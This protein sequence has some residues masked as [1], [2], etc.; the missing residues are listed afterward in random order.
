MSF[1]MTASS[2]M[3]PFSVVAALDI[4]IVGKISFKKRLYSLIGAACDTAVQLDSCIRKGI[5][6]PHT[7]SSAD[8]GIHSQFRQ[9]TCQRPV[10]ASVGIRD[11][12]FC[13]L[14]V[15]CIIDLKLLR[16][17]K[18]LINISVFKSYCYSHCIFSFL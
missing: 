16:V 8:Q 5:L 4:R 12:L 13:D 18:M 9:E 10:S 2:V 17:S 6:C 1:A 7:D 14:S 3:V 11:L 15:F